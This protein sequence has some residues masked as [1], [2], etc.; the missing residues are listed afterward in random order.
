MIFSIFIYSLVFLLIVCSVKVVL[1]TVTENKLA[2]E[3][4]QLISHKIKV[5]LIEAETN[6]Q[7]IKLVNDLNKSLNWRIF[8]VFEEMILLQEFVF[9]KHFN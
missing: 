7:H 9:K 1:I 4:N 2:E 3:N 6:K 8:K 5:E